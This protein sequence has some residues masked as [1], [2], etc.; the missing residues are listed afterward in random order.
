M[1]LR[2]INAQL[3]KL[4]YIYESSNSIHIATWY[5]IDGAPI[6]FHFYQ[7]DGKYSRITTNDHFTEW[8][9]CYPDGLDKAAPLIER[10]AATYGVHWDLE[11]KNLFIQFRRNEM[12]LAQAVMR[13]LQAVYLVGSI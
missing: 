5:R 9:T 6:N 8:M 3:T 1:I 11:N 13:L 12:T 10:L 7:E 4:Y 2:D